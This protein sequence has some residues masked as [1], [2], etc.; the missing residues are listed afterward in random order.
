MYSYIGLVHTGHTHTGHKRLGTSRLHELHESEFPFVSRIEFIRS[1]VSNFSAHV[2]GVT[3]TAPALCRG[4]LLPPVPDTRHTSIGPSH[5][6]AEA[7][8]NSGKPGGVPVSHPIPAGPGRGR[9]GDT[10]I[11]VLSHRAA[12]GGRP[13][14]RTSHCPRIHEQKYSKVSNG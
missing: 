4:R 13:R 14:L 3:D 9:R 6:S 5:G 11:R 10:P 7:G 12:V 1:K 8:P 2:S